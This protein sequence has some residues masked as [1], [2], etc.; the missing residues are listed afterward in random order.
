M[1]SL[2]KRLIA[3]PVLPASL[4]TGPLR[5]SGIALD[6]NEAKILAGAGRLVY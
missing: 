2:C 5:R 3:V 6:Q 4:F 1:L